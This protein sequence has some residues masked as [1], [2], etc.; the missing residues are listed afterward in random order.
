MCAC[1]CACVCAR[2]C[3]CAFPCVWP[4]RLACKASSS[5]TH[6]LQTHSLQQK[7]NKLTSAQPSERPLIRRHTHSLAGCGR[8]V[9][10][11]Y[12]R[13]QEGC[14]RRTEV[15]LSSLNQK[16]DKTVVTRRSLNPYQNRRFQITRIQVLNIKWIKCMAFQCQL[17][18]FCF[19]L[20]VIN[21]GKRA[22][23]IPY[24]IKIPPGPS[25]KVLI[26]ATVTLGDC[27]IDQTH[28]HL[29]LIAPW[30][31][32]SHSCAGIRPSQSPLIQFLPLQQCTET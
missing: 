7:Q 22:Q 6:Y 26:C 10:V 8:T 28:T 31:N 15:D 23:P 5:F 25:F 2:V 9:C 20:C 32:Q 30:L 27:D 29:C 1:A 12:L 4:V 14:P 19:R 24:S 17:C 3:V 16:P 11:L 13:S 18:E 21:H